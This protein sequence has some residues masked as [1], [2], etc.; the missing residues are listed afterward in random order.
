MNSLPQR[1]PLPDLHEVRD[2][3]LAAY[4][5]PERGYHDQVHLTEV[6][7]RVVELAAHER[8]DPVAVGL[9]A[10]FHD[11]V[12]DAAPA[13]E[14]RSAQWAR[15]ALAGTGLGPEVARL[16]LLTEQHSPAPDDTAGRVLCDADLAILAAPPARYAAYV[17][18]V[19]R[20]YA[21]LD[22]STFAAGRLA[23]LL[24]LLEGDLF[25]TAYARETWEDAARANVE[26][27]MATLSGQVAPP[28]RT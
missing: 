25:S 21:A 19:R 17:A 27:E 10:W 5:S 4:G 22:A 9:A 15:R 11:A 3:L 6:L 20:E 26:R 18:G 2:A 8:F 12:H 23:V 16:V 24:H 7:D 14:Q 1:W 28:D 13:E